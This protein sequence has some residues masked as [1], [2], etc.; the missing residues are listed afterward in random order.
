MVT[1]TPSRGSRGD[2][3]TRVNSFEVRGGNPSS[4]GMMGRGLVIGLGLDRCFLSLPLCQVSGLL[5]CQVFVYDVLVVLDPCRLVD[6]D[7]KSYKVCYLQTT[8]N[9]C[10]LNLVFTVENRRDINVQ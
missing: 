7:G 4:P 10:Q 3:R 5:Y 9:T 1:G 8:E 6:Q 2:R